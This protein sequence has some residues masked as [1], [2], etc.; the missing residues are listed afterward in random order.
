MNVIP[1]WAGVLLV[2]AA[3]L[4]ALNCKYIVSKKNREAPFRKEMQQGA[5]L[6]YALM[7]LDG[8]VVGLIGSAGM[9]IIFWAVA[10]AVFLTGLLLLRRNW[11]K[12]L[13]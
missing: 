9:S 4:S 3:I 13:E 2:A 5:V 8:I 6:P 12:Y 7:G 1:F 11:K 10:L